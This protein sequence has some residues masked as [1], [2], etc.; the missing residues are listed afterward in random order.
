MNIMP[1]HEPQAI[2]ASLDSQYWQRGES[3]EIAAPQFG[4]LSVSAVISLAQ[5]APVQLNIMTQTV[6]EKVLDGHGRS[7]DADR[8]P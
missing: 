5:N 6:D 8:C 2:V 7:C 3:E 4:Q 1:K